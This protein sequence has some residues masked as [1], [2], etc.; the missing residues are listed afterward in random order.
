MCLPLP[1]KA[2][3][4]GFSTSPQTLPSGFQRHVGIIADHEPVKGAK[5]VLLGI[6]LGP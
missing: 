4:L 1:A 6:W 3:K 5:A 2:I